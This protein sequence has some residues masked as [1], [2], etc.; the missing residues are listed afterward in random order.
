MTLSVG[1]GRIRATNASGQ[2]RVDS[3]DGMLNIVGTLSGS[4]AIPNVT[5]G[6]GVDYDMTDDYLLGPCHADCTDVIGSI[7]FT[8]GSQ[9]AGMAYDRWH[10]MLGGAVVWVMDGHSV[11]SNP[12]NYSQVYQAVWYFFRI[13]AGNVYLRRRIFASRNTGGFY[14]I[15]AHTISYKLKLGLFT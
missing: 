2:T 7:K 15:L 6:N 3:D 11:T 5:V 9:S 8:L 13:D 4:I 14:T 10:T 12:G 1:A